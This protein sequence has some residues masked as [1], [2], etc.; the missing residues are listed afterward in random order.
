MRRV[1]RF[2]SW[3]TIFEERQNRV[4]RWTDSGEDVGIPNNKP[5]LG[6]T[7]HASMT[8]K[9][10]S[11]TVMRKVE[12]LSKN[13]PTGWFFSTRDS[14]AFEN[15]CK[16]RICNRYPAEEEGR[17][18][19]WSQI[20]HP[21]VE[22]NR[23]LDKAVDQLIEKLKATGARIHRPTRDEC[24]QWVDSRPY[25]RKEKDRLHKFIDEYYDLGKPL[26]KSY[27][28][29]MKK[30]IYPEPKVARM[31]CNCSKD[32]K[33]MFGT[34][35]AQVQDAFFHLPFTVKHIPVTERAKYVAERMYGGKYFYATDHSSFESSQTEL[36]LMRTE[37]R[38][39][40]A[41]CDD[42]MSEEMVEFYA[43]DHKMDS[44][45]FKITVPAMRSSG[46]VDTSFG[47]S[48]VNLVTFG[49]YALMKGNNN[50]MNQILV[51]GDDAI[52]YLD[53]DYNDYQQVLGNWG[54]R[55]KLDKSNDWKS[56]EFLSMKF[57]ELGGRKMDVIRRSSALF[58]DLNN[59]NTHDTFEEKF[60]SLLADFGVPWDTKGFVRTFEVDNDT[61]HA[62]KYGIQRTSQK[63]LQVVHRFEHQ[64]WNIS[65][66]LKDELKD[67]FENGDYVGF[68]ERYI[69]EEQPDCYGK[70][71]QLQLHT[72]SQLC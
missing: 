62:E 6:F 57:N 64:N 5:F 26:R 54:L 40:M 16:V 44:R 51:E 56:L 58:V 34:A 43:R 65:A 72:L 7:R 25:D 13:A 45:Y 20:Y 68:M 18:F 27:S 29:F 69:L 32:L 42:D 50:W 3:S 41:L 23:Y 11:E 30:E 38:V 70:W 46:D 47:N 9:N 10:N 21:T 71:V 22:Q 39:L 61:Y 53:D 60:L 35:Q 24:H 14:V 8:S 52:F 1:R 17:N 48:I 36:L 28:M 55:V 2:K 66:H 15:G 67:L 49:A 12:I 4:Y 31:I 33:W 59:R 63:T 19:K 37:W